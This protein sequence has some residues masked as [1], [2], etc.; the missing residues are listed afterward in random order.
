MFEYGK[1][2]LRLKYSKT[3]VTQDLKTPQFWCFSQCIDFTQSFFL[4][5]NILRYF[6]FFQN[7]VKIA[8]HEIDW[9]AI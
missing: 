1:N 7:M 4:R 6:S 2:N 9:R 5:R 8:F 3:L